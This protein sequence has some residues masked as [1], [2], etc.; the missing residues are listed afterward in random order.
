MSRHRGG[1]IVARG[2]GILV[3]LTAALGVAAGVAAQNPAPGAAP[4]AA[5]PGADGVDLSRKYRFAETF[6]TADEA[7]KPGEVVQHL[8]AFRET[9]STLTDN[10][11]GAPKSQQTMIQARY[12][13]RAAE[14]STLDPKQVVAAIREY[15][16][17]RI[18]PE[19]VSHGGSTEKPFENL[20]IR[21]EVRPNERPLVLSLRAKRTL[22]DAEYYLASQHVF[23]PSLI[24]ALP[25]LPVRV[26]DSYR[27]PRAGVEALLGQPAADGTLNGTLQ[28][29]RPA[30]T[31][32][33]RPVALFDV[34]GE[35]QVQSELGAVPT[36][37]HAQILFTLEGSL[38][39]DAATVDAPGHITR[40]VLA[41]EM[42]I[43]V[44]PTR[45]LYQTM[46]RELILD[47][48][49]DPK[50]VGTLLKIPNY[51]LE[52]SLENS[53]LMYVDP[54]GR[55]R[56]RHP[57]TYRPM[58]GPDDDTLQLVE[59]HPGGPNLIALQFRPQAE[60]EPEA[61]RKGRMESWK[62]DGINVV[63]GTPHAERLPEAN[64]PGMRVFHFDARLVPPASR[65]PAAGAGAGVVGD[66]SVYFDGYV[67]QTGRDTGVWVE[68]TTPREGPEH[69]AFRV[70]AETIL[71]HL[72]FEGAAPASAPPAPAAPA[73]ATS[74]PPAP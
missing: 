68:A 62:T 43:P 63:P 16:A 59:M 21:Y 29:I 36:G 7:K 74:A 35:V 14:L 45:R 69:D 34:V 13:E 61:T 64:W 1:G 9:L 72:T 23:A 19:P 20:L 54:K 25:D 40:L 6:T 67:M 18:T 24:Q 39:G 58:P 28:E 65:E 3:G 56:L 52:P 71:R 55:F 31:P 73:P 48:R 26:G 5:A 27:V 51:T 53:W 8:V 22:S 30:A 38:A 57:Q 41:Q 70:T 12:A 17:V 66:G 15:Q 37:I 49:T 2:L 32:Q 10:P 46:R 60:L 44:D 42:S 47:R 11:G 4:A 33:D 50:E